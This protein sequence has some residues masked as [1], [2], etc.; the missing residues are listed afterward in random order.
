MYIDHLEYLYT[1]TFY[2]RYFVYFT[3]IHTAESAMRPDHWSVITPISILIQPNWSNWD[4][5][6]ITLKL[7]SMFVNAPMAAPL[8][9]S[10]PSPVLPPASSA[11]TS[12]AG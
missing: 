12:R 11:G 5:L 10:S 8:P 1:D 4:H 9:L 2:L 6:S 3:R 7:M